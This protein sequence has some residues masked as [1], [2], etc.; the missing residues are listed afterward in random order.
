M[1]EKK[2]TNTVKPRGN[3]ACVPVPLSWLGKLAEVRII[4]DKVKK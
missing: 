4:K 2:I 1:S 3:S